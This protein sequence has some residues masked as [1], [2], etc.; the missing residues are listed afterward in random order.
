LAKRSDRILGLFDW[1][2]QEKFD[3]ITDEQLEADDF[4]EKIIKVMDIMINEDGTGEKKKASRE[5]LS[6]LMS[7]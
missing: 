3:H 2:M 4:L 6:D 1:N 7:Q 5:A